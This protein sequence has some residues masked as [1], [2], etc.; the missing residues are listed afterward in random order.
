[1]TTVNLQE[2]NDFVAN[3][4]SNVGVIGSGGD[5]VSQWLIDNLGDTGRYGY[6]DYERFG[7]R[8][9]QEGDDDHFDRQDG[10]TSLTE[11][12]P[13]IQH[14]TYGT[15]ILYIHGEMEIPDYE[16]SPLDHIFGDEF[17]HVDKTGATKHIYEDLIYPR[18]FL[19]WDTTTPTRVSDYKPHVQPQ[20]MKHG[21]RGTL[22]GFVWEFYD[23]FDDENGYDIYLSNPGTIGDGR[24]LYETITDA[25]GGEFLE[26]MTAAEPETNEEDPPVHN[27]HEI[28]NLDN[29]RNHFPWLVVNSGRTESIKS[30]LQGWEGKNGM[31][32]EELPKLAKPSYP[33]KKH[34]GIKFVKKGI[35]GILDF[36]S[37]IEETP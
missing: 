11:E 12:V 36:M 13:N 29:E 28:Y 8:I 37:P 9:A 16:N 26:E 23:D 24:W 25:V 30:F 32:D 31:Y 2:L 3:M 34:G 17:Y 7:N 33:P 5:A 19:S 27:D 15:G 4:Y 18:R 20:A 10:W 14:L 1:M 21:D 6:R 22:A 35:D